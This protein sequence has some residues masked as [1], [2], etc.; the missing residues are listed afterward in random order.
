LQRSSGRAH[1]TA[2]ARLSPVR[3]LP[4]KA[5]VIPAQAGIQ[6]FTAVSRL[7]TR[8]SRGFPASSR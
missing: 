5:A 6:G 4:A 3:Y 7:E 1:F 8:A 2:Q